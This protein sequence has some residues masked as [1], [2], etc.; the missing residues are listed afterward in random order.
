MVSF[1]QLRFRPLS[2]NSKLIILK[3]LQGCR[4]ILD[5]RKLPVSYSDEDDEIDLTSNLDLSLS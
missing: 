1:F 4:L 2:N 5:M 3:I